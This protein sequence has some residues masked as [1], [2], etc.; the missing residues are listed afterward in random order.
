MHSRARDGLQY[1]SRLNDGQNQPSRSDGLGVARARTN[2]SDHLRLTLHGIGAD[3]F[4]DGRCACCKCCASD[5]A[6]PRALLAWRAWTRSSAPSLVLR[7]RWRTSTNGCFQLRWLRSAAFMA[8]AS[9]SRS[10]AFGFLVGMFFGLSSFATGLPWLF[11]LLDPREA[12]A[13][14][15]CCLCCCLQRSA[16]PLQSSAPAWRESDSRASGG[17]CCLRL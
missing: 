2:H 14:R 17:Y 5:C 3:E 10:R 16:C 15:G 7:W 9:D 12:A 1:P 8:V 6:S 13:R 11:D 4:H